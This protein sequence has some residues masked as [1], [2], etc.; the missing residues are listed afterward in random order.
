MKYGLNMNSSRALFFFVFIFSAVI[1]ASPGR[2]AGVE[3]IEPH[4][5]KPGM[6]GYGL[7]VFKGSVPERFEVEVVDV[8]PNS[9]PQQ[10]MILVLCKGHGLEKTRVIA[11]MSGSPV[12]IEGR[13]AGAVAYG[14]KFSQDALAGVTPIRNMMEA[15]DQKT[16]VASSFGPD[17]AAAV[18]AGGSSPAMVPIATPLLV[19]GFSP[20]SLAEIERKLSPYQLI[21]MAGGGLYSSELDQGSIEDM[22][23]GAAIGAALMTGDLAMVATGTLTW[24]DGDKVVAFGHP[25]FHGGPIS[26]PLVAARIHTVV[27]TQSVSFK[28]GSPIAVVGEMTNDV[29]AGI[30]G[31][32]GQEAKMIPFQLDVIRKSTGYHEQFNLKL[33]RQKGLTPTLIQIALME[34]IASAAPSYEPTTA[35]I[36]SKLKISNHGEVEYEDVY[37]VM[38][39]SFSM[40]F[41]DPVMFFAKNPFEEVQIEEAKIRVEITDELKIAA[42]ESV[43]TDTDEVDPGGTAV[44]GVILRPYAKEPVEYRFLINVPD[45][46]SIKQL[47]IKIGGGSRATPDEAMPRSVPDMIRYMDAVYSADHLVATYRAPGHGVDVKGRRLKSLPPS[48]NSM[49]RPTN[50]TETGGAP[51]IVRL[52]QKTPYVV[53]GSQR[54]TLRVRRHRK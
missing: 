8:I 40:G 28:L 43:W 48:I 14:W 38:H 26:M 41:M 23:P 44:L 30:V 4:E 42:I 13:L 47:Q 11:G 24:R 33:A 2:A 35:R 50:A 37:A 36:N 25:F 5:I 16:P 12:Y 22:V 6:K 46:P 7:T 53:V 18:P 45:D 21:P 19:S 17:L 32:L 27:A 49:L 51:Q 15:M 54:I 10:D 39:G 31:V 1:L 9:L 52:S 29:Q 34:M 3:I 20:S